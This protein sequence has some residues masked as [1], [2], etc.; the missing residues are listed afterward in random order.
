MSSIVPWGRTPTV[1]KTG[2]SW[3]NL[4]SIKKH[5]FQMEEINTKNKLQCQKNR[6]LPKR[7]VPLPWAISRRLK[8]W[9]GWAVSQKQ[10]KRVHDPSI[11]S[12]PPYY[13][14]LPS[15]FPDL[16]LSTPLP[17]R[18]LVYLWLEVQERHVKTKSKHCRKPIQPALSKQTLF[19]FSEI[20][21]FFL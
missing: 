2:N 18:E 7:S 4:P 16:Q 11:S 20:T 14:L 13:S 15:P 3:C 5:T 21:S 9:G 19:S 17:K 12:P 6:R 8:D 10:R 1:K